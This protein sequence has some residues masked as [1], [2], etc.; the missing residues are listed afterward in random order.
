MV[1]DEAVIQYPEPEAATAAICAAI[2][3]R[4]FYAGLKRVFVIVAEPS[5]PRPEVISDELPAQLT[6]F[7]E[8][9]NEGS[10][11]FSRPRSASVPILDST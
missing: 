11:E 6:W 2:N 4:G 10:G 7:T 1:L 8:A 5:A 3:L 9:L